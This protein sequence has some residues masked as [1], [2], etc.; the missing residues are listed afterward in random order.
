M[1]SVTC[2]CYSPPTEF[3]SRVSEREA[4]V[5]RWF[6]VCCLGLFSFVFGYQTPR[7]FY[8]ALAALW[9]YIGGALA[10]T[11]ASLGLRSGCALWRCSD[12]ALARLWMRS[13]CALVVL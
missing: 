7:V 11:L 3:P 9:R 8:G 12:C 5:L 6:S 1:D 4:M 10:A 2:I 13:G